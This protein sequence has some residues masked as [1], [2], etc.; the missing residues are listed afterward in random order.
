MGYP[1]DCRRSGEAAPSLEMPDIS[2]VLRR[3]DELCSR[4]APGVR[5]AELLDEMEDLLAEGYV[6][7]LTAERR[8]ARLG[9]T[10]E[11][12]VESLDRADRADPAVEARRVAL[13]KRS[14]DQAVSVL[15]ERLA[16]L[17]EH[18]LQLGG[19]RIRSG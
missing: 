5:D 10:L 4:P 8:S 11:G 12:L 16:D 18:F 9:K 15:R 17:R 6:L 19:G 7:T 1:M 3:I 13:S 2:D 14:V